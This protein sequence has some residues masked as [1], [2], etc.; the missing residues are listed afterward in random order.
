[1]YT[2][3]VLRYGQ[4]G[5]AGALALACLMLPIVIRSSTGPGARRSP[6]SSSSS[7]LTAIA[8]VVA[9]RFTVR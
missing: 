9:R 4:T 6:W 2:V 3:W 8:R 1:M 7:L 5:F